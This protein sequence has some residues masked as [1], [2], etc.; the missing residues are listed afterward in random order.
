MKELSHGKGELGKGLPK[1]E[2]FFPNEFGKGNAQKCKIIKRAKK[3]SG[4]K[5]Q[6][7]LIKMSYLI[8]L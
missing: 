6:A 2:R 1:L 8:K 4:M 5:R 3:K 7:L